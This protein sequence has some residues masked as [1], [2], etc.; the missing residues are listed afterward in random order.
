VSEYSTAETL[1]MSRYVTAQATAAVQA[2]L[3][4]FWSANGKPTAQLLEM[5]SGAVTAAT[6]QELASF[7]GAAVEEG[8]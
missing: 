7:F 1:S 8:E 2:A 4:R 6:R 3:A 5:L